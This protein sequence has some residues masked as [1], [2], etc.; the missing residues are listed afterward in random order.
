MLKTTYL[1]AFS[2]DF[3][4]YLV[5]EGLSEWLVDLT[6]W[7]WTTQCSLTAYSKIIKIIYSVSHWSYINTFFDINSLFNR[8]K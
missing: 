4:N 6:W 2:Q 7:K 3:Q 5:I 1:T 8:N